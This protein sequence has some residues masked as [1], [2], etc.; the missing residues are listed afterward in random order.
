MK[1]NKILL[2]TLRDFCE[3]AQG[4]Y[5]LELD[6]ASCSPAMLKNPY[7]ESSKDLLNDALEKSVK[8]VLD[9]QNLP[10]PNNITY[11]R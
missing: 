6:Q 5:E 2:N 9:G 3:I 8:E 11:P 7:F 4:E 10:L 1:L